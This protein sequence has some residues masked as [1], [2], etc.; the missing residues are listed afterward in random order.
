[1]N[2]KNAMYCNT[3][4]AIHDCVVQTNLITCPEKLILLLFRG[5]WI[6][7]DNKIIFD[8]NLDLTNY[9]E[10]GYKYKLMGVISRLGEIAK[11]D[12][13][14]AYCKDPITKKW[15]K[16]NDSKYLK[17]KILKKK[18]LIFQC[19]IYYFMKKLIMSKSILKFKATYDLP[20]RTLYIYFTNRKYYYYFFSILYSSI[21]I[22]KK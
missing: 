12:H 16:Y 11:G 13:F 21:L 1:M 20:F 6:E 19:L 22:L 9:I 5:K 7:F 17:W 14:I 8:E 15:Y 3:C 18:L 10:Y 4:K 2:G